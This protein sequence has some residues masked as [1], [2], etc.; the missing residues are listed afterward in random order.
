MGIQV[1]ERNDAEKQ[2][3]DWGL[4]ASVGHLLQPVVI[5]GTVP[6][7]VWLSNYLGQGKKKKIRFPDTLPGDSD[8]LGLCRDQRIGTVNGH[9]ADF[10]YLEIWEHLLLAVTEVMYFSLM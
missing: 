10:H 9:P 7:K 4:H 2:T 1:G 6:Q 3:W 8:S 5:Q